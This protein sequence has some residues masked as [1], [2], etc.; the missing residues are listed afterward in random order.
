LLNVINVRNFS[1][2]DRSLSVMFWFHC[3]Y[4][5]IEILA[6]YF[7]SIFVQLTLYCICS[8]NITMQCS[9]V[10]WFITNYNVIGII[11]IQYFI[12][13]MFPYNHSVSNEHI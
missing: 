9:S 13:L 11:T 6:I 7:S 8:Q 3:F 12:T 4:L 5:R 10:N 2:R 1:L